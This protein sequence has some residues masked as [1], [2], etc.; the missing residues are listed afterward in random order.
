MHLAACRVGDSELVELDRMIGLESLALPLATSDGIAPT[1]VRMRSLRDLALQATRVTASGLATL[2]RGLRSL[3]LSGT[4]IGYAGVE[5]LRRLPGLKELWLDET[6]VGDKALGVIST[7]TTIEVLGLTGTAVTS[8]GLK[9]LAGLEK[10]TELH[11]GD[12]V[13][14]DRALG[15]L[16]AMN[17]LKRLDVTDTDL[18]V[19]ARKQLV[20]ALR[21]CDVQVDVDALVKALDDKGGA[22]GAGPVPH[23]T[24]QAGSGRRREVSEHF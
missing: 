2:P 18:S 11:L 14:D 12:T 4:S 22:D 20:E 17:Q 6:S 7:R 1:L 15:L 23:C 3:D 16:I 5:H 10:L 19:A 8:A 21:T 9:H 24:G 13:I